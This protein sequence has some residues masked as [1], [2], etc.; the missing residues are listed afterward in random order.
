MAKLKDSTFDTLSVEGAIIA[1]SIN[2]G[3]GTGFSNMKAFTT[4]G[5][6]TWYLP[7]ELLIDR[8]KLKITMIG[9]GAG[10]GTTSPVGSR[11]AGGA[12]GALVIMVWILG[13]PLRVATG[14]STTSI[15]YTVGA[16]GTSAGVAGTASSVSYGTGTLFQAGG[17]SWGSGGGFGGTYTAGSF[18]IYS[19]TFLYS[20]VTWTGNIGSPTATT[21]SNSSAFGYGGNTP[22]G[23]GYGGRSGGLQVGHAGQTGQGYGAGGGG[24]A[25]GS[26]GVTRNGPVGQGGLIMFEW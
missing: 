2:N 13:G 11:G 16:G 25:S 5:S 15:G 3:T 4:A 22:M 10:G 19:G 9:G 12:S 17:G 6:G 1:T 20:I 8:A 7:R 14:I 21:T 26:G 23:W 18:D 24:A